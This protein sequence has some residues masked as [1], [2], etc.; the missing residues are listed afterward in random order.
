MNKC[1]NEGA[2]SAE[3]SG[4]VYAGGIAAQT[5]SMLSYCISGGDISVIGKDVYVGGILGMSDVT[6]YGNYVYFGSADYCISQCKISAA[7]TDGGP[8]YAGGIAGYVKEERFESAS[9]VQYFGGCVTNSYFI[10]EVAS[11]ISYFGS[12][13]GVC[14]AKIY[15]SNSFG[16]GEDLY[17]NFDGNYYSDAF[18][19]AFGATVANG[20]EFV[21]AEDKGAT[22]ASIEQ[23]KN[24]VGYKLI[25]S[26]FEN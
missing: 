24:S 9:S 4:A 14:G 25:L 10:G 15:E 23:I 5:V 13:V 21:A 26:K 20:D 8:V 7:S 1:V 16:S 2:I 18:S 6:S 11:D 12:I 19:N 22:G 3:G 17:N